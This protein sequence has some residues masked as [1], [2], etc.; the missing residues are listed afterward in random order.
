METTKTACGFVLA[1]MVDAEPRY[2]LLRSTRH[3]GWGFPKGHMDPGETELEAAM[4]ETEEEAGITAVKQIAGFEFRD[5]YDVNTQKRGAYRKKVV[6]FLALA[7]KAEHRL[8]DEHNQAGWYTF[9]QAL[10]LL[11]FDKLKQALRQAHAKLTSRP[12]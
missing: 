9:T 10:E 1:H 7:P 8:S 5:E 6:Y 2:L 12:A 4:R 11:K 3:G